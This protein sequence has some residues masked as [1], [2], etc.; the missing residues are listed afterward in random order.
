MALQTRVV[1]ILTKPADEWRTI[2]G[3]AATVE[4]LLRNYAAPL[5][6]IPAVC[7]F[8]GMSLVG[9]TVFG[10]TVRTGIV[11]GFA[12]AV[13]AWA[14][15]LVGAWISAVV[16]E[17]LAPTFQS[18]GTIVQALKLVVYAM[19][20][21]WVAGVLNLV[22]ALAPLG[23]LAA[24][25]AVYLFYV[26]LTPLMATPSDKV[27]PYMVVAA[28]VIIIVSV[29]LGTITTAIFGVGGGLTL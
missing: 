28:I 4:R 2:A 10:T 11:R 12:G 1:N 13:V 27:I 6:A 14:L 24:L 17:K 19:T 5:A 9:V 18:S 7:Q 8:I 20:P 26:G 23:I 15:A 25:Y 16:I 21:I 29:V 3:E 22:P